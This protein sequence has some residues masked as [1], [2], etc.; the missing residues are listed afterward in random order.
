MCLVNSRYMRGIFKT[1][2]SV[3]LMI[4]DDGSP[5][6]WLVK[7]KIKKKQKNKN[8]HRKN[9]TSRQY[10]CTT[11]RTELSIRQSSSQVTLDRR[12][13]RTMTA[14]NL[15]MTSYKIEKFNLQ[16]RPLHIFRGYFQEGNI[17]EGARIKL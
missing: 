1:S 4:S 10:I 15:K 5:S 9:A 16:S 13:N 2:E 6:R 12:F 3:T 7:L 11:V 8:K 14:K 17:L